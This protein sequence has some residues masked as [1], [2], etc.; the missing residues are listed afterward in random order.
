MTKEHKITLWDRI[1][2]HPTIQA[3]ISQFKV[4]EAAMD[5]IPSLGQEQ[6]YRWIL[7]SEKVDKM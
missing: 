2:E 3:K 7:K 4:V 6:L 1:K 5:D